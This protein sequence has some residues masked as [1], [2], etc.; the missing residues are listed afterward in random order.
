MYITTRTSMRLF[1]RLPHVHRDAER[2]RNLLRWC[3]KKRK[4]VLQAPNALSRGTSPLSRPTQPLPIAVC[5]EA[6]LLLRNTVVDSP[7]FPAMRSCGLTHRTTLAAILAGRKQRPSLSSNG[8]SAPA[9]P[10]SVSAAFLVS[11]GK[12]KQGSR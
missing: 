5:I 4:N 12:G 2:H 6:R 10:H 3:S 11:W 1:P 8:V 7:L 9:V